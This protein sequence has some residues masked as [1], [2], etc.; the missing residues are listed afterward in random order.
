MN[1]LTK[2]EVAWNLWKENIHVNQITQRCD[3]DRAT[4]YRWIKRFKTCGLNRTLQL[5]K[6]AH[7]RSRKRLDP[8]IKLRI[9]NLRD[10]YKQCCGQKIQ[11]YL[12]REYGNEVSLSTIYRV[13]NTKYMLRKK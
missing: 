10:K 3:I 5:H 4:V 2:I 12:K 7:K 13:L 1:T 9:F 11:K 8:I 6:I